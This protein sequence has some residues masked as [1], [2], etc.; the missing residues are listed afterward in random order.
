MGMHICYARL[1][2]TTKRRFVTTCNCRVCVLA[3]SSTAAAA[4][5]VTARCRADGWMAAHIVRCEI[6]I[7]FPF[8]RAGY[9]HTA[10]HRTDTLRR[11]DVQ[12]IVS[13]RCVIMIWF[14]YSCARVC[15]CVCSCL[16]AV[17]SDVALMNAKRMRFSTSVLKNQTLR[18]IERLVL[19]HVVSVKRYGYDFPLFYYSHL[20]VSSVHLFH[21]PL[22]NQQI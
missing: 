19:F 8:S 7:I 10:T 16:W 14:I 1:P 6:K 22:F 13:N 4:A 15:A 5:C 11:C 20:F 12:A 2:S 3:R 17:C 9:A 21:Y 18:H